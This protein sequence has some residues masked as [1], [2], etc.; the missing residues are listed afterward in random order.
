MATTGVVLAYRQANEPQFRSKIAE[1][2]VSVE[3]E[4]NR[5]DWEKQRAS[6]VVSQIFAPAYGAVLAGGLLAIGRTVT[7]QFGFPVQVG[8]WLLV[9]LGIKLLLAVVRPYLQSGRGPAH[10][11]DFVIN[12]IMAITIGAVMVGV[13]EPLR[14]WAVLGLAAFAHVISCLAMVG[15]NPTMVEFSSLFVVSLVAMGAVPIAALICALIDLFD[16]DR[17]DIFHWVGVAAFLSMAVH[18]VVLIAMI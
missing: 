8:H 3:E 4:T 10:L 14:W 12:L 18:I 7:G 9:V 11:P 16:R 1:T 13:R 6:H 5:R 17:Y 15:L 2:S